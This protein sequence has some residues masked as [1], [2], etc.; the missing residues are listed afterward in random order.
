M[1]HLLII[2]TYADSQESILSPA[3]SP[4]S[5]SNEII[6]VDNQQ[7]CGSA[8]SEVSN[9]VPELLSDNNCGEGTATYSTHQME[10]I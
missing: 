2:R 8:D 1:T 4:L 7:Y 5:F 9:N 3:F 10:G 6:K